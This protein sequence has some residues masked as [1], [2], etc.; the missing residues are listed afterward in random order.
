MVIDGKTRRQFLIGAGKAALA[1]QI[2]VLPSLLPRRA[3]AQ[4]SKPPLRFLQCLLTWSEFDATWF[5]QGLGSSVQVLDAANNVKGVRL[6]D[7]QGPISKVVSAAFDPLRSKLTLVRG[8]HVLAASNLHNKSKPNCASGCSR[9]DDSVPVFRCSIEH[10]LS[11]S[12]VVYP[13]TTGVQRYVGV[14][15]PYD[16][17]PV[18]QSFAWT[19]AGSKM[20]SITD[21]RALYAKLAGSFQ[22]T[23][24]DP[25]A[26][27]RTRR[28]VNMMSEVYQDYKALAT[29]GKLST[30]DRLRL[31]QYATLIGELKTGLSTPRQSC[32]TNPAPSGA[33][34]AASVDADVVKLIA[35]I[36]ACRLSNVVD[37]V[38]VPHSNPATHDLQH[39]GDRGGRYSDFTAQ[40]G[41]LYASL[42]NTLDG[43]KDTDGKTV[44]DNT[45]AFWGHSEG[46]SVHGQQNMPTLIAGSAG[47]RLATGYY[48]DYGSRPYNNWLVTILN[49]AGIQPAEYE[50]PVGQ[51]G[52]G[53]YNAAMVT[54]YGVGAFTSDAER[55]K[56][57]PFLFRG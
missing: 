2:P 13:T 4:A 24:V 45:L 7:I 49:A 51:V 29:G 9:G 38:I 31:E 32:G 52:F 12:P 17:N 18:H 44:L 34:D 8:L 16:P 39:G 40:Y 21:P 25:L 30:E 42:W 5:P 22:P 23:T 57:L 33:T 36:F 20:P 6:T 14:A 55:R 3:E 48:L 10:V 19:P 50:A 28:Q 54:R 47:G 56:P 53:E 35:A 11:S 37:F 15:R 27:P 1:L 43:M 41:R 46:L 26:D